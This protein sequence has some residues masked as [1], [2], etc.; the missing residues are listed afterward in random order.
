MKIDDGI[1]YLAEPVFGCKVLRGPVAVLTTWLD[2]TFKDELN[3]V[4]LGL[5]ESQPPLSGVRVLIPLNNVLAIVA[6]YS[7]TGEKVLYGKTG[8][9]TAL[10]SV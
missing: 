1:I 2:Y 7:Q 10:E 8:K 6:E 9:D 5:D 4:E 3:P